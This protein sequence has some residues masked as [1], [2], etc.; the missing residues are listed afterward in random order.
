MLFKIR[1]MTI[2]TILLS[3]N[4]YAQTQSQPTPHAAAQIT[5]RPVV[6]YGSNIA[7]GRTFTHDGVK[8]YYE[9]YGSGEPL[10]LVHGNGGSIATFKAQIDHFRKS[11]KVIAMDSRD[12]GRS[13]DSPDRITYEKMT[14]DLAALLDHL[15]TGPVNVLGWSDGGI[16]AL[17][18]GIRH[19]A[20][21]KKIAAMA[22]NLNPTG[23]ALTPEVLA[24]IKSM[25]ESIPPDA[26]ET[27]QG[28]RELKVTQMMLV[29]PHI[30]A[31]ALETITAP[32]LVLAG[33]HDVIR[34]EHTLEIYHHIPNSQLC[35]FPDATHMI[36]YDEPA[37]F[38]AAVERFFRTPF[39]GKDRIKDM[40][41]SFEA[42]K[43]AQQ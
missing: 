14:D 21:V 10:L 30:D 1:L 20:K 15:K 41:K 2:C 43:A 4:L 3:C 29:E 17:L 34:D 16:E 22:A 12:Q 39:V 28:R 33:D 40:L 18:L 19:P 9:V 36:P 6:K 37:R 13:G 23:E 32:T 11:Y 31:K 35:I 5:P 27:P 38:N 24:L 7:A 25:V 26:K 42:L 8:L